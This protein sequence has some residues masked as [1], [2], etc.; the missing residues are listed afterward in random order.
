[1]TGF[2]GNGGTANSTAVA[3]VSGSSKATA[4]AT[5]S[6]GSAGARGGT[7]TTDGSGGNAT[8][9]ANSTSLGQADATASAS[10]GS[11]VFGSISGS[12]RGSAVARA[13][14]TGTSGTAFATAISG[15][16]VLPSVSSTASAQAG[17]TVN[18]ESRAI[19]GQAAPTLAMASGL[20]AAAFLTGAPLG[21]DVATAVAGNPNGT[22]VN[23]PLALGVLAGGYA[24]DG[25]G[26][27][28]TH[29]ATLNF[30]IDLT[31]VN[32][33]MPLRFGF[34]DPT[35]TGLGFD[36]LRL[37]IFKEFSLTASLDQ[38]FT[39]LA[40]A[41]S[42]FNDNVVDL[43]AA[44]SGVTGTLDLKMVMDYTSHTVGD[45]FGVDFLVAIPEPG[46]GAMM[47]LGAG[48]LAGLRRF[49]RR[50]LAD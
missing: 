2:G 6:G 28:K 31:Q 8:A 5:A 42:F 47:V 10:G 49:R 40:S 4:M 14:S 11:Q 12:V 26:T 1:G 45:S 35:G 18:A 34:L 46:T 24:D 38:V 20:E 22:A 7:T 29:T 48:M 3:N 32:P 43:G 15:G 25:I 33:T 37:R 30:S 50:V 19:Y 23:A 21:S 36:N 44:N 9:T 39:T 41:I 17:S 13:N 27:A 16:L